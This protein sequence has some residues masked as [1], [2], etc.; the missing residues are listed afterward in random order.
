MSAKPSLNEN[1][2]AEES[3]GTIKDYR[4]IDSPADQALLA[5]H[6]LENVMNL[7]N[8]SGFFNIRCRRHLLPRIKIHALHGR[9]TVWRIQCTSHPEKTAPFTANF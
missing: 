1:I 9:T 7:S 2:E 3:E 6:L 4:H 8:S 5:I